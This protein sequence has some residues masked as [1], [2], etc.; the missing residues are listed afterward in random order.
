MV[1]LGLL[2]AFEFDLRNSTG[3]SPYKIKFCEAKFPSKMR[4][5]RAF[6]LSI[7]FLASDVRTYDLR[8]FWLVGAP[9][10]VRGVLRSAERDN[11]S[12]AFFPLRRRFSLPN[13][14]PLILSL[15]GKC[16]GRSIVANLAGNGR[17]PSGFRPYLRFSSYA[18][19]RDGRFLSPKNSQNRRFSPFSLF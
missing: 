15:R 3:S 19:T 12:H 4:A 1:K 14:W 11:C 17:F 8:A 13:C 7:N 6:S 18:N 2:P 9:A 5:K 10:P 16:M